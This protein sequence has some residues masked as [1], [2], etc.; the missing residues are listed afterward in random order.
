[1]HLFI[2]FARHQGRNKKLAWFSVAV[3]T[4]L[5][6]DICLGTVNLLTER[7]EQPIFYK[8]VGRL[9]RLAT[10]IVKVAGIV[11]RN[12][13]FDWTNCGSW[14]KLV[15][16]EKGSYHGIFYYLQCGKPNSFTPPRIFYNGPVVWGV[17][18]CVRVGMCFCKVPV[19]GQDFR[20][21]IKLSR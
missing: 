1:M 17:A 16:G 8:R 18:V 9:M 13:E 21:T 6:I 14:Y 10:K 11:T 5:K 2:T 7:G 20:V 19:S 12:M 3:Q 4:I 15:K